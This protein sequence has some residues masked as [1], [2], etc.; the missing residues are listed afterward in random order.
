MPLWDLVIAPLFVRLGRPIATVHRISAGFAICCLSLIS[1]VLQQR[2]PLP[3]PL[4][5]LPCVQQGVLDNAVC[6]V[7]PGTFGPHGQRWACKAAVQ[8][9]LS[10]PAGAHLVTAHS[11]ATC[12]QPAQLRRC[13]TRWCTG[14]T[15]AAALRPPPRPIPTSRL[16]TGSPYP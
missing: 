16:K 8:R 3:A 1:G 6:A 15:F 7:L 13:A 9:Q 4:S 12:T 11:I 2:E 5:K 10:M 14:A